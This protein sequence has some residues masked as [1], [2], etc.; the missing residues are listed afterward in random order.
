[1]KTEGEQVGMFASLRLQA[2]FSL[3]FC[4]V[5]TYDCILVWVRKLWALL[6]AI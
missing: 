2:A 3:N 1:M 4:Q 6:V 5:S